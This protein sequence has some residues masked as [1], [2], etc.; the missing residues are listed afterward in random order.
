MSECPGNCFF[1]NS[2]IFAGET[3]LC[4]RLP[5][6]SLS[7]RGRPA[8]VLAFAKYINSKTMWKGESKKGL[9]QIFLSYTHHVTLSSCLRPYHVE[10]TSSRPITEVKQH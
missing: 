2:H 6:F 5:V 8:E 1:K 4:Q 9:W 10:N 3:L 7:P